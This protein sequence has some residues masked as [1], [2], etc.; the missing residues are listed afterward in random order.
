MRFV[1]T[2]T[3]G[4]SGQASLAELANRC[5][6]GV[7]AAFEEP[8]V[9]VHL[10]GILGGLERRFRR[11]FVETHELLGRGK[12]LAAFAAGDGTALRRMAEARLRW[13]E[14]FAG[15]AETFFDISKYFIRGLHRPLVALVGRPRIVFLVRDPVEN[16]RSFVNR[17]KNFYL[18]NNRPTDH[19]N[20]LVMRGDLSVPEL[21]FWAWTEGYLRGLDLVGEAGLAPARIVRTDDLT[22]AAAMSGHFDALG[23]ACDRVE[24][25]APINTNVAQ[26][27]AQTVLRPEDVDAF[28]AWR[29]KVPDSIWR[30]LEFMAGYD[31][32][33][34]QTSGRTSEC[35]S[36]P[37]H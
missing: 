16:M 8:G 28:E 32:R 9:R 4:R 26:G 30:R 37:S 3:P 36:F 21:Y 24:T 18:D 5:G 31:P 6:V 19:A 13:M 29:A 33:R 14:R 7:I 11:R 27:F 35:G 12:V 17:G 23:I 22:D 20:C 15:S 25:L 1:F 2:V 10:P 34:L